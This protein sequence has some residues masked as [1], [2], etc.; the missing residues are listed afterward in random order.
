M[1]STNSSGNNFSTPDTSPD[2]SEVENRALE[3]ALDKVR[4]TLFDLEDSIH[5]FSENFEEFAQSDDKVSQR[6]REVTSQ[7]CTADF[8]N[9]HS[10]T[11]ETDVS[12]SN[13]V[14]EK[15]HRTTESA[16]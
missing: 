2:Q 3:T 6:L 7:V 14:G 4:A 5:G 11:D 15:K 9:Q 1:S 16:L 13:E 12:T 8:P 10:D